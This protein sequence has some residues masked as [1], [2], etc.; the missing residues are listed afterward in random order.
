[1]YVEKQLIF[2]KMT[3]KEIKAIVKPEIGLTIFNTTEGTLSFFNGKIW[4]R[5]TS[6]N[7]K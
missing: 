5:V 3:S 7:L 6:G 4:R 2:D 1:M